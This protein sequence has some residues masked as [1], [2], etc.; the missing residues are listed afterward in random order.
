M[1]HPIDE[2]RAGSEDPAAAEVVAEAAT[3]EPSVITSVERVAEIAAEIAAF[4]MMA[5]DI[6]FVSEGRFIPE[7]ALLQ[8]A[9]GRGEEVR[10]AAIDFLAVGRAGIEPIFDLIRRPD[11][12]IIAHSARQDLGLL[13]LRYQVYV[14]SFWDTQ[15]AAAFVGVG[16]QIGYGKLVERLLGIK[17]DKG[18]QFTAWLKRPL[19]ARQIRYALDDVRYLPPVWTELSRRLSERARLAWV[20][21]ESARL[22]VSVGP[23]PEPDEAYREVKGWRGLR[24]AQL[25]SLRELAGWRLTEA[26]A[27]NKPL[28]W[29]LP[30]RAM[31][32]LCRNG[33][34]SERD[35][36]AVRGIGD[37]ITRRH[38]KVILEKIAAGAA[39][40]PPEEYQPNRPGLSV[41]A[42][43]WAQVIVSLVQARCNAAKLAPRFVLT[44]AD[45]E[46]LA[47]WFDGG[48]P[49]VE[50]DID[51]LR[52]WRREFAGES[53][54]A[55]LRG[56]KVIAASDSGAAV[57]L[58]DRPR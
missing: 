53:A 43:V 27:T 1:E 34:R 37:G 11:I 52:G 23:L 10:V 6:E 17:L 58:L 19:S 26:L 33:A 4:G 16:D 56:D 40:P 32:D 57:E 18:S 39:R 38:G 42:Q 20:A 49:A 12:H 47:A 24:G 46:E 3:D 13:A 25:G 21:E 28:S 51:L 22:A 55:W 30:A 2:S 5:M 54:L 50:P 41:R 29:V 44:R 45:A 31:V 7:L 15:I 14:R 35:L 8:V 36:R 9:W 48:D